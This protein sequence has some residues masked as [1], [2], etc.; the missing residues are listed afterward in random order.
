M[1]WSERYLS[2][3]PPSAADISEYIGSPLWAE[4]CSF[5]ESRYGV[6]PK[7]E[8]SVCSGAPGWNVKYRKGGRAL[9]TLYP[10][11]GFFTCLVSVGAREAAEA[12]LRL[13]NF[14]EAVR[15]LYWNTK[16]FN[17]ARW[18]MIPVSSREILQDVK[19]LIALRAER[20]Q[21]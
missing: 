8:Y 3:S 20:K 4:L 15:S 12:E 9:C 19:Q 14:S 5:V 17:G 7:T 16:P 18:L 13:L 21:S 1:K 11:S 6:L 10:D 2:D